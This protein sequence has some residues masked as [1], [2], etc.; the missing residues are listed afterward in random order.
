MKK[1]SILGLCLAA[2]FMA[3]AQTG[4]VKEVER[5]MKSTIGNYPQLIE[6]LKPAFNNPETAQQAYPYFVAG[7]GGF[8]FYDNQFAMLQLGQDVDKKKI[9]DAIVNGYAYLLKALPFDSV[10]DA[11]GKVKPKY[12]KDIFKIINN[13]YQDFNNA[14]VFLWE[15]QDFQGAYDAW[16]LLFTIPNEPLLGANKPVSYPDSTLSDIAYNQALAAWQL[17]DFEKS[18]AAFDKAIK[19]GY[20]KKGVYDYAISVAYQMNDNDKMAY[21][22]E[23]AYPLYGAEDSRYI[24][25]MINAKILHKEFEEAQKML[26]ARIQEDPENAQLYYIL[27]V[28]YEQ[29]EKN[30]E[31]LEQYR[32]SVSLD[33]TNAQSY[34]QLGRQTFYLA[35]QK[36]EEL[37]ASIK[38]NAEYN[39][40]Y[41]EIVDPILLDAVKYLEKAYELDPENMRDALI[42]LRNIYYNLNDGDNLERVEAL[43]NN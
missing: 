23:L 27:G 25:Y 11:K 10:P 20:N 15:A 22:A 43:L 2:G 6:Q 28:L 41:A 21:Y 36:G 5:G 31:A 33:P 3:S 37:N 12:S 16:E 18:L 42:N 38:S 14:G 26:E 17:N 9:G 30:A 32:K 34:L 7:K 24:G 13:H 39:K 8:D 40:A 29:Q 35:G 1:I 19:H 4:L